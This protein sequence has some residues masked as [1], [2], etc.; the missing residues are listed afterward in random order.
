MEKCR[1]ASL[2]LPPCPPAHCYCIYLLPPREELDTNLSKEPGSGQR[3]RASIRLHCLPFRRPP[4]PS[5]FFLP[6]PN[7]TTAPS[8]LAV[9]CRRQNESIGVGAATERN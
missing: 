1:L 7:C 3:A 4:P 8:A 5:S 9:T 2:G 6:S